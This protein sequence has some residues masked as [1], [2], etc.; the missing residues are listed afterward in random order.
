M[1]VERVDVLQGYRTKRGGNNQGVPEDVHLL[2][3]RNLNSDIY[4]KTVDYSPKVSR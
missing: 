4:Q 2:Y 1:A 3:I